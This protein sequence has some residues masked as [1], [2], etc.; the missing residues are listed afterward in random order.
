MHGSD[1]FQAVQ[2]QQRA[3]QL[4][5]AVILT[6]C[7]T[8]LASQ[9]PQCSLCVQK[10]CVETA[11]ILAGLG[12]DETSVASALLKDVLSKSMMTEVQLRNLVSPAVADLVVKVGRL[13]DLCQVSYLHCTHM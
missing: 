12:A 2:L 3:I 1:T 8:M 11:C 10:Q 7:F 13:D 6:D 9:L 5:N 4:H